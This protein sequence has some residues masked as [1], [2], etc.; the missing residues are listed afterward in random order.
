MTNYEAHYRIFNR[1][2]DSYEWFEIASQTAD[3]IT[4]DTDTITLDGV[5]Y[6]NPQI[7]VRSNADSSLQVLV[8]FH[9]PTLGPVLV[10]FGSFSCREPSREMTAG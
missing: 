2:F 5:T 6:E 10:D 3:S 9:S 4:Y 7:I 8:Q 1:L